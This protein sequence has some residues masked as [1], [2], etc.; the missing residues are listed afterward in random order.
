MDVITCALAS[1][2]MELSALLAEIERVL[3]PGGQ[4]RIADV[5]VPGAYRNPFV[6]NILK[7]LT[8]L[9]FIPGEGFARAKAERQ[10]VSNVRTTEE[11]R[12]ILSHNAF[13]N[14]SIQEF[15]SNKVILPGLIIIQAAKN[16]TKEPNEHSH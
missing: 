7:V 12:A 3:K 8:F 11:W 5:T 15:S 6:N 2:H 14:V 1:H 9:Y 16:S 13:S 4:L 10:A